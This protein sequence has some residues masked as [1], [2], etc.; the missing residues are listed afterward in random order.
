MSGG[1]FTK[2]GRIY[3]KL[4]YIASKQNI[5]L[6]K[7]TAHLTKFHSTST[8]N[9][10]QVTTKQK[11]NKTRKQR[12][13][14]CQELNPGRQA[15]SSMLSSELTVSNSLYSTQSSLHLASFHFTPI[16]FSS[17]HLTALHFVSLHFTDVFIYYKNMYFNGVGRCRPFPIYFH[18]LS[19]L[20][21][22]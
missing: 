14:H 12:K 13:S 7:K 17:L 8:M 15:C 6:T 19:P 21:A 5:H 1:S 16:P 22:L 18:A 3:K 10:I 20:Y 2:N 4:T 11:N 9:R